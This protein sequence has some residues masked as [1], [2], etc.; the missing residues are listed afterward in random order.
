M[1]VIIHFFLC[2]I[3]VKHRVKI[4]ISCLF[5]DLLIIRTEIYN[6]GFEVF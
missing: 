5:Q 4:G 3:S 1:N 2:F 6:V